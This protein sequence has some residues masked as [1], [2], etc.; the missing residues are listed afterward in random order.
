SIS[1]TDPIR[2]AAQV[3]R[4]SLFRRRPKLRQQGAAAL[5]S[6]GDKDCARLDAKGVEWLHYGLFRDHN[7]FANGALFNRIADSWIAEAGLHEQVRKV[8]PYEPNVV[9]LE[10]AL[11]PVWV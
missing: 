6:W 2:T 1:H 8:C 3:R 10:Y 7:E 4:R 5:I 9:N 11:P